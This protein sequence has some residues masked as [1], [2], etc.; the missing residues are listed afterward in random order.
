VSSSKKEFCSG[1]FAVGLVKLLE[2]VSPAV[3]IKCKC[4]QVEGYQTMPQIEGAHWHEVQQGGCKLK[5]G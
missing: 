1:A 2:W 4:D 5:M 3:L